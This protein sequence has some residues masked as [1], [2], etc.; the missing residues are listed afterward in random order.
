MI[1]IHLWDVD[2]NGI[3]IGF[4]TVWLNLQYNFFLFLVPSEGVQTVNSEIS[5]CAAAPLNV[6][7]DR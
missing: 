1:L 6:L 4:T 5:Y 2:I 7:A 3:N